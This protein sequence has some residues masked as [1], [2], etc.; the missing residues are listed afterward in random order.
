MLDPETADPGSRAVLSSDVVSTRRPSPLSAQMKT[1]SAHKPNAVRAECN[2]PHTVSNSYVKGI[3][4]YFSSIGDPLRRLRRL[5]A[6]RARLAAMHSHIGLDFLHASDAR[7]VPAQ[8][9]Q[10]LG[11]QRSMLMAR[12]NASP[13]LRAGLKGARQDQQPDRNR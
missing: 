4:D 13:E 10:A 3:R 2:C 6:L 1:S 7:A 11:Q 5:D 12:I 8:K 9:W